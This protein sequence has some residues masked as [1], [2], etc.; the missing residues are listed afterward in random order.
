MA[1]RFNNSYV[2][3]FAIVVIVVGIFIGSIFLL[4]R[5]GQQVRKDQEIAKEA[6]K[7]KATSSSNTSTKTNTQ[8]S[9]QGSKNTLGASEANRQQGGQQ[10]AN[11]E[12]ANSTKTTNSG[13][14]PQTGVGLDFG[15]VFMIFT[16]TVAL[17]GYLVSRKAQLY[18]L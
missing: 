15:R 7:K 14:I 6:E 18:P 13:S 10:T 5:R 8:Q 11:R 1:I 9:N 12:A 17:S 4:N 3:Y 2:S 16:L